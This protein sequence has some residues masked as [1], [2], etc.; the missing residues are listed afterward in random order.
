MPKSGS[1]RW[2]LS[3][4]LHLVAVFILASP[5]K[6]QTPTPQPYNRGMLSNIFTPGGYDQDSFW[7]CIAFGEGINGTAASTDLEGDDCYALEWEF[8]DGF[9]ARS[10]TFGTSLASEDDTAI[11]AAQGIIQLIAPQ[12]IMTYTLSCDYTAVRYV[13]GGGG[14]FTANAGGGFFES[15]DVVDVTMTFPNFTG[16]TALGSMEQDIA[17]KL[18]PSISNGW[19]EGV[20]N[21]SDW[22]TNPTSTNDG[23]LG[24]S[25]SVQSPGQNNGVSQQLICAVSNLRIFDGTEWEGYPPEIYPTPTGMPTPTTF[26]FGTIT[27]L[28]PVTNTVDIVIGDP[29]TPEC[30]TIVPGYAISETVFGNVIDA[31]WADYEVCA[32][33]TEFHM[34]FFDI[35]F[36]GYLLLGFAV[37]AVGIVYKFFRTG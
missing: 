8:I 20:P 7:V 16:D 23:P 29:G 14:S 28:L 13:V 36:T 25:V 30:S 9:G 5:A 33:P 34:E 4:L 10:L 1:R 31:G 3:L 22:D 18:P 37:A 2:I 21:F 12:E 15:N 27:P 35:D 19:W 6:A 11:E 17:L 26:G 24:I 32:Q